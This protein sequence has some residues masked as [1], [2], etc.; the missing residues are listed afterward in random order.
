LSISV[1]ETVDSPQPTDLQNNLQETSIDCDNSTVIQAKS[2]KT[3]NKKPFLVERTSQVVKLNTAY[4]IKSKKNAN[5]T[6]STLKDKS[7]CV[8]YFTGCTKKSVSKSGNLKKQAEMSYVDDRGAK[9]GSTKMREK[10]SPT[11]VRNCDIL[12]HSEAAVSQSSSKH[13]TCDSLLHSE[14][15]VIPPVSKCKDCDGLVRSDVAASET[16]SRHESFERLVGSGTTISPASLK[17]VKDSGLSTSDA[18]IL[19]SEETKVTSEKTLCDSIKSDKFL[20]EL[21]MTDEPLLHDRSKQTLCQ[22]HKCHRL[23]VNLL[24][25]LKASAVLSGK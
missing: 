22:K 5:S 16:S 18:R 24:T 20:K 17:C 1:H 8:A 13:K 4:S 11:P 23:N 25:C 14:A 21:T 10:S 19:A 7:R 3:C 12:G 2:I 15:A 9:L 6:H